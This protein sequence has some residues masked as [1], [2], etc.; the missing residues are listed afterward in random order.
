MVPAGNVSLSDTLAALD[1][2]AFVTVIVKA[3]VPI[4][5]PEDAL[6]VTL[7]SALVVTVAVVVEEL[8]SGFASTVV[9]PML[10]VFDALPPAGVDAA[11]RSTSENVAEAP[12]GSVAMVQ[13]M[14]PVAPGAGVAQANVRPVVWVKE[15]K[16]S[17]TTTVSVI[18]TLAAA[19]GPLL[20]AVN[21]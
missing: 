17:G 20:V 14:V 4:D 9:V 11:V 2:P 18:D 6:L 12:A 19:E 13:V 8:L 7:T 1:G 15:T 21:V 16:V 3:A 5:A 10:A